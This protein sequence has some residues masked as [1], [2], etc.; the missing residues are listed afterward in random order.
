M[1][2]ISSNQMRL[3]NYLT[4][5]VEDFT[6]VKSNH[7]T[8]YT[9]GPTVYDFAHIGNLRT[10]IFEDLLKRTLIYLGYKVQHVMNIT[11]IEDKIIQRAADEKVVFT[12]ITHR[13]EKAFKK[14]LEKLNIHPAS[15]YPT[16]TDH[17]KEIIRLIKLLLDKGFAYQAD[18]GTVYFDISRFKG[19]GKL[20]QIDRQT[21]KVG[22]SNRISNDEYNKDEVADFALWKK[23]NAGDPVSW[24]APWGKGRPGWHIECSTLSL[25]YLTSFFNNEQSQPLDIH[26]GAVDLLFPHHTNEVAQSE[27]ATGSK[28]VNYWVE[29]EH[30][31]V[32]GEKMSKSLGNYYTLRDVENHGYDPLT[33]RYLVL[34]THY[35]K[36]LNF[37]WTSLQG[38]KNTLERLYR[39]VGNW[40]MLMLPPQRILHTQPSNLYRSRFIKAISNDLN[41]PQALA[42]TWQLVDDKTIGN[43]TKLATIL[44]FDKVFGLK[45]GNIQAPKIP[46][47]ISELLEKRKQLRRMEK[48]KEAD[49]IRKTIEDKGFTIEDTQQGP[50]LRIKPGLSE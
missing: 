35:R 42:V 15:S 2:M 8:F 9:C 7:V 44:A 37:T 31:L 24:D 34:L 43:A 25:R 1:L 23:A 45:L 20:A 46:N 27:A 16:V 13:Y 36:K 48:F 5:T 28:F 14:D 50:Q 3:Y 41:L 33:F 38:A 18:D 26:A 12:E 4:R 17:I 39:E 10:Y 47:E 6:P 21:L 40:K 11:D 19:Y 49:Q 30:L 22:A 29:G 32:N